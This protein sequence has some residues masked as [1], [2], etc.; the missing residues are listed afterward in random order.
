M[1]NIPSVKYESG[2]PLLNDVGKILYVS[3]IKDWS[4]I[5]KWYLHLTQSKTI[6]NYEVKE[7]VN[8]LLKGKHSLSTYDKIK[9]I[10]DYI[11]QNITY[12]SVPFRQSAF[13]PQKARDVL[14]TKIG[15][16]KDMATLFIT[17]LKVIGVKAD[18]VL[19]NTKDNGL[20]KNA[21][22]GNYFDHAIARVIINGKPDYFDL[23]AR[24]FPP[25]TLPS[26]DVGAFALDITGKESEP[27]YISG[28]NLHSNKIIRNSVAKINDDNSV[29]VNVNTMRY[30]AITA[31]LRYQINY[32][33][34]KEQI[35]KL[36]ESLSGKFSNFNVTSFSCDNL[37]TLTTTL[38]DEC[39]FTLN[40]Y[41][42][43][44]GN[45]KLLKLPW[46]DRVN[47][48]AAI[49]YDQRKFAY[50]RNND[51]DFL[52]ET[53]KI[54]LPDGYVPLEM[55]K[56]VNLK[57][58]EADYSVEYNFS[59]GIITATRSM[60]NLRDVVNPKDYKSFKD[61]INKVISSD[62]TQILL[63]KS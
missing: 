48:S 57:C 61:F 30:G 34:K 45:Y 53:L 17:M 37:D 28:K 22:P 38:N 18:Y 56:D 10:Y 14:V 32:L 43:N 39:S 8:E 49:S 35:K 63:K 21:L 13:I 46:E 27:F 19:V 42:G 15:D 11:V 2:M 5:A 62:L 31:N 9:I 52:Q 29:D 58:K 24:N 33:S 41:I 20:N 50:D 3:T 40:Q 36:N 47:S 23:T 16:C 55:P 60:K 1:K 12:S 25:G 44:V 26:M 4:Y 59:N 6:P 7:K 54:K 51:A